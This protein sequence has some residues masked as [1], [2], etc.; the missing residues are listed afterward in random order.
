MIYSLPLQGIDELAEFCG[1]G[2]A[3][4]A[5]TAKAMGGSV[6]FQDALQARLELI[7]PAEATVAEL[8]AK[9]PPA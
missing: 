3:V 1:A 8:L 9:L 4:A 7:Q 5:W 2:P 6:L